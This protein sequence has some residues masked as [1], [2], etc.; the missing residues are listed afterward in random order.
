MTEGL[1]VVHEK[2][3]KEQLL[4]P[5]L[6]YYLSYSI[7]SEQHIECKCIHTKGFSATV[8]RK[9]ILFYSLIFLNL[10]CGLSPF[11]YEALPNL[12]IMHVATR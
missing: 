10:V 5:F 1:D 6:H 4:N 8:S 11:F 2:Y 9:E 7:P 12:F 3:R